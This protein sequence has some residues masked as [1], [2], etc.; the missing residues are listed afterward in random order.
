MNETIN[1]AASIAV[2]GRPNVG[3]STLVNLLSGRSVSVV[4]DTPAV[5][6]D[7]IIVEASIGNRVVN[8][9]DTGGFAI[10]PEDNVASMVMEQL[11]VAIDES[12]VIVC[13]FDASEAPTLLDE[14]IVRT[15]RKNNRSTIYAANKTDR[16]ISKT[17]IHEYDALA[18]G[19]IIAVSAAHNTG[20]NELLDKVA[21]ALPSSTGRVPSR[22]DRDIHTRILVLGRP[23][24]GKST[25]IN[26][27]VGAERVIV[28]PEPGTTRDC[29][30]ITCSLGGRN[31]LLI[32]SAGIRR[33]RSIHHYLEE[34]IVIRA[35]K[36]INAVDIALLLFDAKDGLVQQDERL[37]N[38][39][40][41][42]G[43]GLVIGLNKWDLM[44]DVK[45]ESYVSGVKALND[46]LSF[47][48]AVPMSG[49]TGW[50]IDDLFDVIFEVKEKLHMRVPTSR[51]NEFLAE[52]T[53]LHPPPRSRQKAVKIYYVAQTNTNP[54]AFTF[55]TNRPGEVADNWKRYAA[56]RLREAFG[57][58][59]VPV[60]LRFRPR[61]GRKP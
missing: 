55:I 29:I 46:Y 43:R 45:Y 26:T 41:R 11:N 28:D 37:A 22:D 34:M 59:G 7:R 5:T 6:R 9:I 35:I 33:R 19:E 49:L 24:T 8:I 50:N 1:R 15:L 61:S 57:F 53:A 30:E 17:Q 16:K 39:I 23:N 44:K 60:R 31:I 20:I 56:S 14:E 12:D 21:Q 40:L 32:D 52:I 4:A 54:P 51:L 18:P 36:F 47:I 2:V 13:L 3:K 48:P 27:V 42:K 58:T 38:M 25:F 10:N